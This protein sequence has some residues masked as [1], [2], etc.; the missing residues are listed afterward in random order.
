VTAETMQRLIDRADRDKFRIA[1]EVLHDTHTYS[2]PADAIG[3]AGTLFLYRDSV[4][5]VAGRF[6]TTHGRL[7][8]R[9]AKSTRPEHRADHV[10]A[11]SGERFPPNGICS[12]SIYWRSVVPRWTT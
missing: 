12:A 6:T 8:E 5:I 4:R 9:G 2:M 3:I 10:A 11:V 1:G 7:F